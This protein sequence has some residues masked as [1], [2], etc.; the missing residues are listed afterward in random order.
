VRAVLSSLVDLARRW[1][2][3]VV[4]EGVENQAQL[5]MAGELAIDAGQGYLLGRPGDRV[6]IECVDIAA[7]LAPSTDPFVRLGLER[8]EGP[9]VQ[10]VVGHPAGTQPGHEAREA[11]AA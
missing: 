8:P 5:A 9:E 11:P 7:L 1:G 6:D 4:A 3:L 2:A 10:P